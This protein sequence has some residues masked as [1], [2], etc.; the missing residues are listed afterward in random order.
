MMQHN[1]CIHALQY[2]AT[3]LSL[4]S[5]GAKRHPI[6]DGDGRVRGGAVPAIMRR[7]DARRGPPQIV[8]AG[9]GLC[10]HNRSRL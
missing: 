8:F 3:R 1:I 9:A 6:A 10:V 7:I 2:R 5:G 4:S